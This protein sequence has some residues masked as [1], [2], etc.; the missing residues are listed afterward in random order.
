M[1]GKPPRSIYLVGMACSIV[2]GFELSFCVLSTVLFLVVHRFVPLGDGKVTLDPSFGAPGYAVFEVAALLSAWVLTLLLI[3]AGNGLVR[4]RREG[5]RAAVWFA[6]AGFS[7]AVVVLGYTLAA[8]L[9]AHQA[10]GADAPEIVKLIVPPVF[11][12]IFAVVVGVVVT[13]PAA[14]AAWDELR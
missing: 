12:T 5:R 9:P 7:R 6:V 13:R 8:L 10:H 11:D 4:M 3:W 1:K 2:G 14:L